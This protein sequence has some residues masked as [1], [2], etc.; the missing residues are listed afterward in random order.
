MGSNDFFELFLAD[1][2]LEAFTAVLQAA[3]CCLA[4]RDFFA[5]AMRLRPSGLMPL[6]AGFPIAWSPSIVPAT[7]V[8]SCCKRTISMSML[9][10][11]CLELLTKSFA[12]SYAC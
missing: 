10:K 5:S 4:Q 6:R 8:R 11:S 1:T 3:F 9:D 2:F 12:I 7:C